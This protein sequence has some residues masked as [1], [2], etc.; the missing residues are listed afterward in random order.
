VV[1]GVLGFYLGSA[2]IDWT[3]FLHLV[4]G[5]WCTAAGAGGLNMVVE[6]D[7]DARMHRTRLRPIPSGR[8]SPKEALIFSVAIFLLG[9]ADLWLFVNVLT[10]GLALFTA[11]VYVS[12]Y[13]PLKSR[14]S[15]S[16]WVGAVPGAV[17]PVMGWAAAS[18]A[19]DLTA[20]NLVGIL[21]LWQ[22]PHFLALAWL[23]REDYERVGFQ[24]L[25]GKDRS[26]RTAS[27]LM[28]A[29]TVLLLPVTLLLATTGDAGFLYL[30]GALLAGVWLLRPVLSFVR[31]RSQQGARKVF[32]ATITYLP[33]LLALIVADRALNG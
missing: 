12:V 16:T 8:V 26:G 31:Q 15:I 25:P 18:G 22:F 4:F 28:A 29:A 23:Y 33:I 5:L 19:L 10:A 7:I 20:L 3:V 11:A 14:G 1:T 32:L 17:P 6:R 9:F 27:H 24:L 21:Y 2:T 13:T 30:A